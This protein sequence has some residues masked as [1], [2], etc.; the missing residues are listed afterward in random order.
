MMPA[1]VPPPGGNALHDPAPTAADLAHLRATFAL[2]LQARAAGR[3]PFA[4]LVVAAD[5]SELA[6]ALNHSMPPGGDPT[7]HAERLAAAEAARQHAPERLRGATLYSNAEPCAMCAGAIYW[8]GIGRVVYGLAETGL[9][10]LTGAHP[11]NPTLSLPC[12]EVFVRGQRAT[13][14][15][16]PLLE[17]EAALAHHGFWQ[18]AP[19]TPA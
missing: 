6:R 1:Q 7:C 17:D 4:A 2:A 11:E 18:P 10:A 14:V 13:A 19:D 8:C 12:R 3:H 9:L 16:G 5:G 15:L